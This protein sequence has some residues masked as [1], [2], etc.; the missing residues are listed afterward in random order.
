MRMAMDP[1]LLMLA[2]KLARLAIQ[3]D[4][5]SGDV[6]GKTLLSADKRAWGAIK[7]KQDGVLSGILWVETVFRLLDPA[8][9]IEYKAT[10]GDRI[11]AGTVIARVESTHQALVAGERV[12]LNLLQHLSGIATLTGR[13]VDAI[14]G[15][16]AMILDTRKTAPGLR[17]FEKYAVRCGGGIN[18]R[19]G[20]YDEAMIKENHLYLSGLTLSD[21]V[22]KLDAALPD[23][24]LTAESENVVEAEAAIE[25]R[26]DVVLLDDFSLED[27]RAVVEFR[28]S[29]RKFLK[30]QL[31][32]SG[33]VNLENVRAYAETGIERISVGRITHSA[34]ALDISMKVE[35]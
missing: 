31:E 12:T 23:T 29:N 14:E 28:N 15:T 6:T 13:F 1:T 24:C 19:I 17:A 7:F 34:P 3:E 8:V 2:E 32:V 5:G 30:T 20:L 10:D 18:H 33:G 26:A 21:A 4:V 25:G 22:K 35:R 27:I 11:L 9:K 16:R